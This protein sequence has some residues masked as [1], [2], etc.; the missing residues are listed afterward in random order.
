MLPV[1]AVLPEHQVCT[2]LP[3]LASTELALVSRDGVLSGLQRGLVEFL[4][5]ELGG[6]AGGFA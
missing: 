4:R 5:G 1:S 6:D 3:E 2:D